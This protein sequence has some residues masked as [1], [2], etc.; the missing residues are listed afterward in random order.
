MRYKKVIYLLCLL[1]FITSCGKSNQPP[2]EIKT[3][4]K[5]DTT[6]LVKTIFAK[7]GSIEEKLHVTGSLEAWDEVK[8]SSK[9]PGRVLK[10]FFDE[11]D[12]VRESDLLFQLEDTEINLQLKQAETEIKSTEI[13]LE[14]AKLGIKLLDDKIAVFLKQTQAS[15]EA[16]KAVFSKVKSGAREQEKEQARLGVEQAQITLDNA[17]ISLERSEKLYK[18]NAI[19]KPQY[20][21]SKLQY[22]L[23]V[24]RLKVAKEISNLIESG[25]R[26]EDKLAAEAGVNVSLASQEMVETTK[27]DKK[28]LEQDIKNLEVHLSQSKIA[29]ELINTTL[30]NTKIFAPMSG[31]I[32]KKTV[33]NGEM[34]TPGIPVFFISKVDPLKLRTE[35][36]ETEIS[37]IKLGF[38]TELSF[39]A[40]P[41]KIF[42]GKINYI[43]PVINSSSR[44]CGIEIKIS[45][46]NKIFKPG[47]FARITINIGK[48]ENALII[49]KDV[50]IFNEEKYYVF[51][52]QNEIAVKKDIKLGLTRDEDVE[53]L[54]GIDEN[55]EIILVGKEYVNDGAKV[56]IL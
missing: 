18:S 48:K 30:E 29:I 35:I 8:V 49:P 43:S 32:I 41:D 17:K 25:S 37:N 28:L 39:D 47:M 2:A 15:V 22:D 13:L 9:I 38:M 56:K 23:A 46:A 50:L 12:N 42:S 16:S 21:A 4:E 11:G 20:E 26:D 55:D 54:E 51:L 44:T 1:I 33:N 14:K 36:P 19:P 10:V 53:V 31:V 52:V 24:S 40:Y 45:N 5:Q 7:R 3:I 34:A 27:N 6:P